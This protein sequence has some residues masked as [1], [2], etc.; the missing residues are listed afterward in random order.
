MNTLV[1]RSAAA[2]AALA[3]LSLFTLLDTTCARAQACPRI[4]VV[5]TTGCTVN[6][7]LVDGAG[8]VRCSM[9]PGGGGPILIPPYAPVGA[10]SAGG[11]TYLFNPVPPAIGCTPCITMP[12]PMLPA[13]CALVCYDPNI[14]QITINPCPGPC[15]P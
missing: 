15:L 11:I 3:I 13:C 8:V 2:L 6:L 10:Q 7:C 14:C 5:N 12:G 9:I 1:R 4:T